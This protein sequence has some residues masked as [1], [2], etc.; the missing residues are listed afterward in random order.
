MCVYL[1]K[2]RAF[3][4]KRLIKGLIIFFSIVLILLVLFFVAIEVGENQLVKQINTSENIRVSEININLF[5]AKVII[6]DL[7]FKEQVLNIQATEMS[8]DLPFNEILDLAFTKEKEFSKANIFLTDTHVTTGEFDI[9][10]SSLDAEIQG[11]VSVLNP[12]DAHLYSLE[13]VANQFTY[14]QRDDNFSVKGELGNLLFIGDIDMN[15]EVNNVASFIKVMDIANVDITTPQFI[16]TTGQKSSI[17]LLNAESS[18]LKNDENFKGDRIKANLSSDKKLLKGENIIIDFPLVTLG[19]KFSFA[20]TGIF[21]TKLKVTQ[22]IKAIG[23]ELNPLLGLLGYQIPK[24]P[25][26]LD[27]DY[28]SGERPLMIEIHPI[29]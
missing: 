2:E 13:V 18:W 20:P 24:G 11:K 3:M 26:T 5:T 23:E 7:F 21:S 15:T 16:F 9:I 1:R 4:K 27:V 17:P 28:A 25:F 14:T 6:K 19:G 22:L 12:S 10:I 8:L 29:Q